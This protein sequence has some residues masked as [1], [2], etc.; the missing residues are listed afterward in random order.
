[1]SKSIFDVTWLDLVPLVLSGDSQVKAMSAGASPQLQEVSNAIVECIILA[2]LDELDEDVVDL[3]AWQYHVDFYDDELTLTQKRALVETSI[4]THRHKGTPYAV[5][6]VV[7]AILDNAVVEEWFDYGGEPYYF[8][9][10]KIGGEMIAP[11]QYVRLKKAINTVKNARSH[12][13]GV[14]LSRSLSG[15]MYLGG[16]ISIHKRIEVG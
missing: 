7:K 5:E 6:K 14:S 8:R 9:V 13:D 12:L 4:D 16:A 3:L 2:R 1:M 15:T 10:V 11:D